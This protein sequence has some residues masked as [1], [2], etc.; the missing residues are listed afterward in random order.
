MTSL[1][2]IHHYQSGSSAAPGSSGKLPTAEGRRSGG[3]FGDTTISL[4]DAGRDPVGSDGKTGDSEPLGLGG[5][6]IG[7]PV[8]SA[9]IGDERASSY[10]PDEETS[11]SVFPTLGFPE[12]CPAVSLVSSASIGCLGS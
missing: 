10:V 8:S 7:D 3:G 5:K 6:A 2:H 1:G 9:D 4:D 11:I 12:T